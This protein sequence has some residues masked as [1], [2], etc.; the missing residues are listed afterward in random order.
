[1]VELRKITEATLDS[2]ELIDELQADSYM[3]DLMRHPSAAS[4][5][6][7]LAREWWYNGE[8]LGLSGFHVICPGCVEIW[9]VLTPAARRYPDIF[10]QEC[11]RQCEWVAEA[12]ML[13]RIQATTRADYHK[14]H[15]L[16]D[17]LGFIA[18]GTLRSYRAPGED[19]IIWG[20]V[21]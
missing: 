9:C 13:H 5:F 3:F 15:N 21:L 10:V 16:M 12:L 7:N 6:Q 4:Y 19:Y 20:K 11:R 8:C 18:E 2:I 17:R 1:M 14:A